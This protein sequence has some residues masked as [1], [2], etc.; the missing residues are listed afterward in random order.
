MFKVQHLYLLLVIFVLFF[1]SHFGF[2]SESS[3]NF[4]QF[5]QH[6]LS[7][8]DD[9]GDGGCGHADDQDDYNYYGPN[10]GLCNL[11][12]LN[13][14]GDHDASDRDGDDASDHDGNANDRDGDD[15]S[16]RVSEAFREAKR[17]LTGL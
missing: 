10:H 16:D 4:S 2:W 14:G 15:A 1:T 5:F 3:R 12:N 13:H 8:H 7:N 6:N 11:L 17:V 9:D